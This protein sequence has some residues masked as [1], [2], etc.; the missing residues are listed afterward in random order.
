MH[1]TVFPSFFWT[2]LRPWHK[3]PW[4]QVKLGTKRFKA[5]ESPRNL[6]G[7]SS[8]RMPWY[9][10][11]LDWLIGSRSKPKKVSKSYQ[12]ANQCNEPTTWVE[13]WENSGISLDEAE[14]CWMLFR[15]AEGVLLCD[16]ERWPLV[17]SCCEKQANW[18]RHGRANTFISKHVPVSLVVSWDNH[19]R[20]WRKLEF[21]PNSLNFQTRTVMDQLTEVSA[22]MC[23]ASWSFQV[24]RSLCYW[25][26]CDLGKRY[27][28]LEPTLMFI[29]IYVCMYI[30]VYQSKSEIYIEPY[31]FAFVLH[32]K[33]DCSI[34]FV[35]F[36]RSQFGR[37][38]VIPS[39]LPVSSCFRYD[40]HWPTAPWNLPWI[41]E[42]PTIP[43]QTTTPNLWKNA[44][45]CVFVS[46]FLF[47]TSKGHREKNEKDP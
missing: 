18:Q 35:V 38:A 44:K 34:L 40:L 47:S 28:H 11:A 17:S 23:Q 36:L 37:S 30:N 42:F 21:Y 3:W 10:V 7:R 15:N 33:A 27:I 12:S 39:Y 14:S 8:P 41:L 24:V 32:S 16:P 4:E 2:S 6:S 22:D 31:H 13:K 19:I 26:A 9:P 45:I 43:S 5:S 20:E 25:F 29:Y 1:T 46:A